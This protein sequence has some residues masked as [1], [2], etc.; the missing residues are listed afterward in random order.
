[1]VVAVPCAAQAISPSRFRLA[2]YQCQEDHLVGIIHLESATPVSES[3]K[4]EDTN[5]LPPLW[6]VVADPRR[7]C[8]G[9]DVNTMLICARHQEVILLISPTIIASFH[10]TIRRCRF[11]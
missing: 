10:A 3:P 7:T 4:G 8:A 1:M 6:W 11:Y 5:P 9:R 2:S